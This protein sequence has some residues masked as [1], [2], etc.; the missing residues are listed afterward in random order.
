MRT[1]SYQRLKKRN[2]DLTDH[3]DRLMTDKEYLLSELIKYGM[4]KETIKRAWYGSSEE[5]P[6]AE[7]NGILDQINK[8]C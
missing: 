8:S 7:F 6:L 1:T 2:K 5:K 4:V 3:I